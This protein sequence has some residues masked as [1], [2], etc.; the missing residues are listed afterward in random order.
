MAH[1]L[2]RRGFIAGAA[3]LA[4]TLAWG[5]QAKPQLGT[6]PSVISQPPRQW[7]L[8][9]PPDVYP[10]PDILIIDNSFR[11]YLVGLTAIHRLW[12]G[13]QWAEGPA[14][15][16]EG[17]YV[18]FSDVKGNTQYRYVWESRQVTPFRKPSY[19]SLN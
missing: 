3:A 4:P 6:P 2:T 16:G 10:D 5:Q 8:S 15:S 7:G 14:W 9:A 19:T 13:F 12:T 11:R 1:H 17:R 18:V